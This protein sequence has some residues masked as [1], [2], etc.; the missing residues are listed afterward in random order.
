MDVLHNVGRSECIVLM[1]FSDQFIDALFMHACHLMIECIVAKCDV[2]CMALNA[3]LAEVSTGSSNGVP[4]PSY[5][6][7]VQ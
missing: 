5:C 6:I 4:A 2:L 3:C 7:T 1:S